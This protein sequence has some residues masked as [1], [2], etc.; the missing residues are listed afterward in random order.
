[1][2]LSK[3]EIAELERLRSQLGITRMGN[4]SS[5]HELLSPINSLKPRHATVSVGELLGPRPSEDSVIP[6][7]PELNIS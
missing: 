6:V 4:A 7:S 3:E 1:M 5:R 2:E